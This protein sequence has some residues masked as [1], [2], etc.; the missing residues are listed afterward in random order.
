METVTTIHK[1]KIVTKVYN[2]DVYYSLVYELEGQTE[3]SSWLRDWE[4]IM[5]VENW[6]NDVLL[7]SF[8]IGTIL[9]K[10]ATFQIVT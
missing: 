1:Y 2:G 9:A 8:G 6:R 7:G 5:V 3:E 4:V 10:D